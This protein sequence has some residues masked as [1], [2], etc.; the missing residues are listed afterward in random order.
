M[1]C[2]GKIFSP[3]MDWALNEFDKPNLILTEFVYQKSLKQLLIPIFDTKKTTKIV[4][5]CPIQKVNLVSKSGIK[6]LY[7]SF[8]VNKQNHNFL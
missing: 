4:C 1:W 5:M 2:G 8:L 3:N 6:C 7:E